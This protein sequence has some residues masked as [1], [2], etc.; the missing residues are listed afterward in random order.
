MIA[1][2]LEKLGGTYDGGTRAVDPRRARAYAAATNDPY[3]GYQLGLCA[4]PV[5]GAVL[6][7][8]ALRSAVVDIV[9]P[10]ALPTIVHGEQDMHFHRPLVPGAS[11]QTTAKPHSVRRGRSGTRYTI[12]AVSTDADDEVPVL[13]QYFTVF[14]RGLDGGASAG[15][16]KPGHVFPGEAERLGHSTFHVHHDQTFRYAEASGDDLA[17]HLDDEAARA[18]GLPAI[19]LQ[20][21]CTLAMAG[22]AVLDLVTDGDPLPLKR[23]AARFAANVFPGDDVTVAIHRIDGPRGRHLH[24]FKAGTADGRS[25]LEHGLVEVDA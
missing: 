14:L 13:Y 20:G 23:L 16:D 7:W 19:V 22:R 8:D 6:A 12:L 5:F 21:L 17:I 1:L 24:P 18:A 15:P 25:V 10:E 2:P 9:P 11:L 4:P 3:P